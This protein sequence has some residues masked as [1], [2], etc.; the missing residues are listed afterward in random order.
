MHCHVHYWQNN[1]TFGTQKLDIAWEFYAP[2]V[3]PEPNPIQ[4]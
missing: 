4:Q 2:I 1:M 3:I